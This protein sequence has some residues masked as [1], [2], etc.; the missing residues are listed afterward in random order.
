MIS[1]SSLARSP[2]RRVHMRTRTAILLLHL[3]KKIE[4]RTVGWIPKAT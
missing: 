1:S 2:L 3:A 4:P